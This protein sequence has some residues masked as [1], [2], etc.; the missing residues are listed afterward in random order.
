MSGFA[1]KNKLLRRVGFALAAAICLL[2]GFNAVLPKEGGLLSLP[3][4]ISGIVS[5]EIAAR[6]LK[7]S[8]LRL[9]WGLRR[10]R[11]D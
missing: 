1:V 7:G 6:F 10:H 3:W 5:A 8:L 11:K 2:S 9:N 4:T